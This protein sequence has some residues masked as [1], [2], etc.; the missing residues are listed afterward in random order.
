M[1]PQQLLADL[2]GLQQAAHSGSEVNIADLRKLNQALRNMMTI[3]LQKG[4][5]NYP[6]QG[7]GYNSTTIPGGELA[8]L[9]PQSIQ[10]MLD[11]AT[12]SEEHIVAW[13][14]LSK[15]S[16][17]SPVHEYNVRR[18]H[19]SASLSPFVREGGVPAVSESNFERKTVRMKYM[20]TFR[21][22]TDPAAMTGLMG[23]SA[24]AVA[25]ASQDGMMELIQKMESFLFHADS[26]IN[27]LE[28]DGLYK[29]IRVGAPANFRDALGATTSL[30]ELQE[31]CGRMVN[32]PI[33][34]RPT[35]IWTDHR[36]WTNLQNQ[37][38]AKYGRMDITGQ[39]DIYGGVGKIFVQTAYGNIPVMPIPF[40]THREHPIDATEGDAAPAAITPS[41][42]YQASVTGSSFIK[43]SDIS[44]KDFHYVIEARGDGGTTRFVATAAVTHSALGGASRLTINDAAVPTY[45]DNSIREY[46]V[47]RANVATGAGAPTDLNEYWF[48]GRFARNKV[49]SGTHTRIDDLN[50]HRPRTTQLYILENRPACLEWVNFLD[51]TRR[52]I[53][54][55]RSATTQ[56]MIMLFGALKVGVPQKHWILDN[57]GYA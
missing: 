1:I 4:G 42:A 53:T 11:N 22:V 47:Y 56:F 20:A 8:P 40:L 50:L 54:V 38:L 31:I 14:L 26:S 39:R 5:V 46:L 51:L 21:Q 48:V 16:A 19:G 24:S 33:Y 30:E 3:G 2:T 57:V 18:S 10:P 27:P 34:A 45:G 35:E 43:T 7:V 55:S 44:G 37:F 9:V 17:A 32:P 23:P 49:A 36:V 6:L 28:Y 13:K 29:S 41:A 15:S 12:F 25:L 52:P